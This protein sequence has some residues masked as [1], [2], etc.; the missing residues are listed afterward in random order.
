[1]YVLKQQYVVKRACS[2]AQIQ[3][4]LIEF[5]AK[6]SSLQ[7]ASAAVSARSKLGS[8]TGFGSTAELQTSFSTTKATKSGRTASEFGLLIKLHT[9]QKAIPEGIS[10]I[11]DALQDAVFV[12]S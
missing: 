4:V 2:F 5:S 1:M 9:A 11:L 8:F 6:I 7:L 12:S 10:E 3:Q